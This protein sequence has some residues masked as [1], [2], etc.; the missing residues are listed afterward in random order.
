MNPKVSVVIP[1]Y[2]NVQYIAETLDSVLTQ[3][4][5]DYE[6]V[7]ADHS[8]SDGTMDVIELY[9]DNPKLRIL[10]PTPT[11]GGAQANWNRVSSEARGT[12][13]KL[14]CGDDII[15]PTALAEQ[16]AAF[17]EHPTAVLVAS[18]R[19]LVDSAGSDFIKGRGLQGISG[20]VS[21][22]EA[23]RATVVAGSNIFGEP[24]CV[25]FRRDL[26]EAEGGWDNTNPYLIDEATY[27]RICFHGDVVALRRSLA[28]F[29]ISASQWSVRLAKQQSDQAIAFHQHI[30]RTHPGVLSRPDLFVGNLKAIAMSYARRLAYMR[31]RKRMGHE[32]AVESTV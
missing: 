24:A 4:Y 6:V 27:A 29:R 8:S 31:L 30:A 25:L 14:V 21:G 23:V 1:A 11:G 17:E 9:R 28:K 7:I 32:H 5:D 16:V 20:L 2:N 15:S 13:I 19:D 12:Y 22:S 26:L 3:T 18:Q 10:T